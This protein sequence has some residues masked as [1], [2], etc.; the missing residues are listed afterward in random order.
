MAS[1][2]GQVVAT[3]W[4]RPAHAERVVAALDA[5]APAARAEGIGA[6]GG[7]DMARL[8]EHCAGRPCT[9]EDFV[10]ADTPPGVEVIHVGKNSL[11]AL[12]HFEKRFCRTADRPGVAYGYNFSGA[13]VGATVGPGFFT[14]RAHEGAPESFGI[15]YFE[16]PPAGAAL[17]AGWPR[18]RP[19]EQ[20]LQR[21]V[22]ARMIDFMRRVV[23]GVTIGRAWRQG[24]P[25]SNYFVLARSGG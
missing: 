13:L 22:Y 24:K 10:P 1:L 2:F 15:N 18:V 19:N 9:L 5:L 7:R 4:G 17:P 20:G 23:P 16:V 25:T 12:S 14:A 3:V 21:F 6:L 11:P 8:W